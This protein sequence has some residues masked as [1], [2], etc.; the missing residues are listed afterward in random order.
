[1]DLARRGDSV[2][3]HVALNHTEKVVL[4]YRL[5]PEG[6]MLTPPAQLPEEI[7]RDNFGS[8]YKRLHRK[9][10]S[11]TIVPGNNAFPI[12]PTQHRSLTPREAARIQTKRSRGPQ[13]WNDRISETRPSDGSV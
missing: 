7:R 5:I 12:H 8:T 6:G 13:P 10:P 11:L 3:N 9:Q 1:M 2:P 4:R